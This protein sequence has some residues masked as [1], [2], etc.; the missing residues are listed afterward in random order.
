[1]SRKIEIFAAKPKKKEG[2][3]SKIFVI[4]RNIRFRFLHNIL[5]M[6]V[7]FFLF[8]FIVRHTG[9][10]LYGVYLMVMTVTGYFGLLDLGVMS[11]LIKYVSEYNGAGDTEAISKILNVSFSFYVFI[12][13]V[14]ALFLF[15]CSIYIEHF[16]SIEPKN[17]LI[18]K[19]LFTIAAISSLLTWPLGTF[20]GTVQGLNLWDIEAMVNM[21]VQTLTAISAFFVFT[22]GYNIVVYIILSQTFNVFGCMTF[23]ILSKKKFP[24]LLIRFPCLEVKTFKL[25]FKFSSFMFLSSLVSIFLWQVHNVVIGYFISLSAVT[26]YAVA[27][28]I[29]N[30]FRTINSAIGA[31]S[32]TI[33]SAME[34]SGDYSGQRTLVFKG[35]KYMSSV[36]L[37][38]VLI[39][40]FFAEPFI[41]YWMGPGFQESV[42][43]ARII[44]LFYLFQGIIE[45]ATGTL[46]AKGVV[47]KPF[48]ITMLTAFINIVIA[49]SLIKIIGISGAALGLTLSMIFVACPLSL[50]IS[51]KKLK[52]SFSE[53]FNKSVKGNLLL[54]LFVIVF[55]NILLKFNYPKNIYFTLFEMAIIFIISLGFY[56]LLLLNNDEKKEIRMLV[57][58]ERFYTKESF[59]GK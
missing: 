39:M 12:G 56:Y 49:I 30:N 37:P 2:Y 36:F 18:T 1:M 17:L 26:I 52:I 46:S 58:I 47:E 34:G 11:A 43:P 19:Q 57:G 40:F 59:L 3:L 14:T 15:G 35:T 44:I 22:A 20:R 48:Y 55:S 16:F 27:Y 10:E 38:I 24:F 45:P 53:Y 29:Q 6:V 4:G 42:L 7:A 50:R 41:N 5:G 25:I 33:A 9:H 21:T 23:Y 13:L 51:L 32:F 28:N 8:P 54:Y 31:P